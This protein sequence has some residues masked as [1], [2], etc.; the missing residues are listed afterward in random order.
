MPAIYEL[1]V[2][3]VGVQVGTRLENPNNRI[4]LPYM[5]VGLYIGNLTPNEW[6]PGFL[7]EVQTGFVLLAPDG[8]PLQPA[9]S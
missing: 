7:R 8:T 1:D 5:N 9:G 3:K 6:P 2:Y 4:C